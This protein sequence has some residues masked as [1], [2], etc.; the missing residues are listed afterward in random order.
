MIFK[1]NKVYDILKWV[2]MLGIPGLSAFWETMAQTWS[3]PYGSQ[4]TV[5]INAVGLLLGTWL[6]ISASKY[7]KLQ[8]TEPAKE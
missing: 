4:I 2:V 7:K 8:P 3:L 6:C 5:T 1:N